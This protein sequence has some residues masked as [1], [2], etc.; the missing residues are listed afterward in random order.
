MK[1]PYL[2]VITLTPFVAA[3]IIA[4]VPKKQHLTI[5]IIAAI[6]TFISL[7]LSII[8]AIKYYPHADG[9][10]RFI[11][12][13]PWIKSFGISYH[14]G[15]DGISIVLLLLTAV[16]IFCGIFASWYIK[17][18]PKEFFISLLILVTGVFG[19]FVSID[20]FL[21]F[22]Y[23][24]LAVIPMFLLIGIWG[25]TRK[26]YASMKLVLY[27]L[28]GSAFIIAGLLMVYFKAG[29]NTFDLLE[30]AKVNFPVAFQKIV[31]ILFVVGFGI[32]IPIWPF[33][34]W[35]PDGH[36]AAPTATSMLHAGVLL[37]LGAYGVLRIGY[38][39]LPDAARFFAPY[40]AIFGV[41]N[42]IY[43]ALCA[44]AQ[45]DLK[46][47]I[48]YSSVSHMGYVLLGMATLNY[49]GLNG[50]VLQC[51]CHG[52]MTGLMFALVGY[53][54]ERAHTREISDFGGLWKKMPIIAGVFTLAGSASMGLPG[55][56]GFVAELF[57]YIG[58][59]F[60]F[61]GPYMILTF[62]ALAGV[63]ITAT[64]IVR[65][66]Q[67]V[68]LKE[69]DPKWDKLRDPRGI[70]LIPFIILSGLIMA[71]GLYPIPLINL[72]SSSVELIVK[73]V[74]GG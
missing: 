43:G 11:E 62:V 35:S 29:L 27:I 63:V 70:E 8:V 50:A 48:G 26:E 59:V 55:T 49:Y 34:T 12:K 67:N 36:V 52:I 38:F 65:L 56:S 68:F 19:V 33:H 17:D 57:V 61:K 42:I 51:F 30:V 69:L 24:E 73:R 44:M 71:V 74:V 20:M 25:S 6:A 3:L 40:I 16:I 46:Y 14:L 58:A 37:K 1:F 53:I 64:Y 41:I 72:M 54:Y 23:Y 32:L 2:S 21:F 45:K 47:V 28:V 7:L 13:V 4:I 15:V 10:F 39:L 9:S 60:S 66:L 18:R 5:K 31:F 22:F